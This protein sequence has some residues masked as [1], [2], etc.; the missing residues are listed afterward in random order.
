MATVA[1]GGTDGRVVLGMGDNNLYTVDLETRRVVRSM[2]GHAGYIHA[3][4]AC[5]D[6]VVASGAARG[7]TRLGSA[8]LQHARVAVSN[9]GGG[10]PF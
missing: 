3:V 7:D 1:G 4:A 6:S 2:A 8:S 9:T 10:L 5:G